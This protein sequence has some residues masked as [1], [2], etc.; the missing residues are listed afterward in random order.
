MSKLTKKPPLPSTIISSQFSEDSPRNTKESSSP[1]LPRKL[2]K[3]PPEISQLSPTKSS[4]SESSSS[5]MKPQFERPLAPARVPSFSKRHAS[6]DSPR[7]VPMPSPSL[8]RESSHGQPSYFDIVR[9]VVGPPEQISSSLASSSS[10]SYRAEPVFPHPRPYSLPHSSSSSS[11]GSSVSSASTPEG[12]SVLKEGNDLYGGTTAKADRSS[13]ASLPLPAQIPYHILPHIHAG[14]SVLA[15]ERER[16]EAESSTATA[17]QSTLSYQNSQ[18]PLP[19]NARPF[20][21][22]PPQKNAYSSLSPHPPSSFPYSRTI[23]SSYGHDDDSPRGATAIRRSATTKSHA[24]PPQPPLILPDPDSGGIMGSG[25]DS[26]ARTGS[27]GSP[28]QQASGEQ[29][30]LPSSLHKASDS[31]STITPN[32]WKDPPPVL[33]PSPRPIS[34]ASLCATSM[35]N[36]N[37]LP[38]VMPPQR[39]PVSSPNSGSAGSNTPTSSNSSGSNPGV[40]GTTTAQPPYAPF[41]SHMPPPADSYIEVETTPQ[42]YRLNVRLPGFKRDGITLA[43]KRRRILHLIADS[44]EAIPN[45]NTTSNSNQTHRGGHFERRIS[46][47]YDADLVGVRAEFDG[48]YLRVVVPRRPV[49]PGAGSGSYI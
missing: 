16:E 38:P 41:L 1:Q 27:L 40:N 26:M 48:E 10:S 24:P 49:P 45:A 8:L 7:E 39:N 3:P 6:F 42:E 19:P 33:P 13:S 5:H 37:D 28:H 32:T 18:S 36:G 29:Q 31:T 14:K 15:E 17:P 23:P 25:A 46:F 9:P 34:S 21:S 47:G 44:Y 43:T 22:P 4:H 2:M 35:N 11:S 12:P 30:P 20:K